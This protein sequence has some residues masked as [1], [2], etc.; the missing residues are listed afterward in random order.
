MSSRIQDRQPEADHVRAAAPVRAVRRH[1]PGRPRGLLDLD[2]RLDARPAGSSCRRSG[3][4][5]SRRRRRRSQRSGRRHRRRGRRRSERKARERGRR[6]PRV[7]HAGGARRAASARSLEA[8]RRDR[9]RRRGRRRARTTRDPRPDRGRGRRARGPDRPPRADDRRASSCSA[10]GS[11]SAA[12]AS[13]SG[14]RSTPPATASGAA[15]RS[16]SQAERAAARALESGKEIELEPMSA[17]E[18]KLVH[19]HLKDRT[20]ARDV[21]R[22]RGA[23]ALRDRRPAG[24]GLSDRGQLA[25]RRSASALDPV[26][27]LLAGDPASLS[28]VRDRER[29]WDFHV[30]DSLSALDLVGSPR[31]LAD[32]GAGA[33]FPGPRPRRRAPG[34]EVDLIESV[35]RKA[36]FIA[37]AAE[38]GAIANARAVNE[39]S[40]TWAA[41]PPPDGGREALRRRHR[42]RRRQARDARRARLAPAARGRAAG[43]LEG[44]PRRGGGGRAR[45]R[46]RAAR[47]APASGS[48]RSNRAPYA[49]HR[50]LHVIR[51]AG[52]TPENLPRRPGVAKRKP[53]G[54]Q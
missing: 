18:R 13:A 20:G 5:R 22:G 21:Q 4:R 14:S 19:D 39:R 45:A 25:G 17:T 51:K 42:A 41:R 44:P 10:T 33:G 38:A 2:Q 26:L 32:V 7:R 31:R 1:V 54:S 46:R 8:S 12:R 50:H 35:A 9:P 48:S 49:E 43:R 23:R 27:E 6:G 29:A 28:S 15:R 37:R 11:P 53:Y 3:R 52:P 24:R 36:E 34:R 30:A 16:R 47:D 40:E